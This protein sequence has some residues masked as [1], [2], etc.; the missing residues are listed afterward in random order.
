[1]ACQD[2]A[3]EHDPLSIAVG[4]QGQRQVGAHPESEV[5]TAATATHQV[6]IA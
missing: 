5:A 3:L 1:M 4:Q 2:D 6:R